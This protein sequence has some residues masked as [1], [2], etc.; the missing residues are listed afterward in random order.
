MSYTVSFDA[1][2]LIAGL[3][4]Q[5]EAAI[6]QAVQTVA[7]TTQ[8][9]WK[10][11]VLQTPGLWQPIKDRYAGSIKV[12]YDASGMGARIYSDDP[13]ATP[14][15]TGIPARDMK[16][17]LDTS[18]KTRVAKGG[19]HAGQR[20]MIIPFRHN[21]PGNTA[22]AGGMPAAVYAQAKELTKSSV[23]RLSFRQNQLGVR[24]FT[25]ARTGQL[26]QVRSRD[27][28]WGDRLNGSDVPTRFK[29][30]VRFNTSSGGQNSSSF[31]TFRVMGEWSPGW[32]IKAQPGRYIVKG[33]SEAAHQRLQ[34][35]VTAA[36]ASVTS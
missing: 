30:M 21:T 5:L 36:I 10:Q 13:M 1:A 27:Y 3:N 4:L 20:Y 26:L 14:I 18:L 35:E 19:K 22:L 8:A 34:S 6:G 24:G 12:E 11:T 23:T 15:E 2:S 33:I 32:I 7:L 25:G 17:M 29:G 31:V 9:A 16:R 28:K